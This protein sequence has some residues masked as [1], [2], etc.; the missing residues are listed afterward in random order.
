MSPAAWVSGPG[1]CWEDP[2]IWRDSWGD[3]QELGKSPCCVSPSCGAVQPRTPY[4]GLM[5]QS[6]TLW[7]RLR[8][9][10][11]PL[12]RNRASLPSEEGPGQQRDRNSHRRVNSSRSQ[13]AFQVCL[14]SQ[15]PSTRETLR[16]GSWGKCKPI[17]HLSLHRVGPWQSNKPDL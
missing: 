2:H 7:H 1:L 3:S 17:F 14:N 15:R 6:A 13:S 5:G 10:L 9:S 8:T 12:H 16:R 4:S 11:F